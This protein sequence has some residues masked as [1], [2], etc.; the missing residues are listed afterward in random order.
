MVVSAG[1]DFAVANKNLW[2]LDVINL[3][4]GHPILEPAATDPLVQAVERAVRAGIVVV[5]SAGNIGR[6]PQTGEVGYAGITPP[7][8]APSVI[9][10]GA[11]DTRHTTTRQDD[12][13]PAFS[14]R[15]PTWY[16]GLA[17]PDL[18]AP[19]AQLVANVSSSSSLYQT[20][21]YLVVDT[22]K[23]GGDPIAYMRFS[24]TSMAAAVTT[25]VVAQ[26]IQANRETW[27]RGPGLNGRKAVPPLSPNTVKAILQHTALVLP[28]CD[29]LTQGPARS[30][31]RAPSVSRP[32]STRQHPSASGG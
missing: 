29:V 4:L 7:G 21:P 24:G 31:A 2:W 5:V 8:N 18:V 30:T 26:M 13:V 27:G 17:K 9:T 11:L 6:N 22:V 12:V 19:G 20:N 14:S 16:D 10:V 23:V 3:S 1:I 25:G 28:D 32:P 15:R